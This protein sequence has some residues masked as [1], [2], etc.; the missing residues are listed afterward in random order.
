MF[1]AILINSA[2][3]SATLRLS[4]Q[5]CLP[6]KRPKWN[7]HSENST[8]PS[9]THEKIDNVRADQAAPPHYPCPKELVKLLED[10]YIVIQIGCTGEEQVSDSFVRLRT[11]PAQRSSRRQSDFRCAVFRSLAL[12]ASWYGANKRIWL[13]RHTAGDDRAFGAI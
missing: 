12:L 2:P 9:F 10:G 11:P 1:S 3:R 4:Y 8:K 6:A 13:Q 7:E 5:R